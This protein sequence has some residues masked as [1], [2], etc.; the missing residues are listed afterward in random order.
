MLSHS[1]H[2]QLFVMQWTIACQAPLSMGFSRQEYWS[3]F[4]C[5]HPG[6]LHDPGIVPVSYMSSLPQ[7]PLH[8]LVW[9][10]YISKKGK[11][12]ILILCRN[13]WG[14]IWIHWINLIDSTLHGDGC[15]TENKKYTRYFPGSLVDKNPPANAEDV[16]LIPGQGRV[17]MPWSS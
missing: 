14:S 2:D 5:P 8:V 3:G 15:T 12:F 16:G 13:R 9:E 6:D 7:V 17:H 11:P 10:I 1:S 4:S